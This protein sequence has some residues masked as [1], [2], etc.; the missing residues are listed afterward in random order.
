M[1]HIEIADELETTIDLDLV[2]DAARETLQYE[3]AP[4][5]AD[6]TIVLTGDE[7]VKELNRQYLD[8]DDTTDVL[9]FPA[10]FI[11]PDTTHTYLGDVIISYPK[12]KAQAESGGH[13]LENELKLL[14][15]HGLLHLLG[16]DHV[17]EE[18]KAEMWAVQTE[19]LSRL[20]SPIS[21]S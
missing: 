21:P 6:V 12:A 19:I 5:E 18:E 3:H 15:V 4:E 2:E 1:I 9:S 7:Q 8:I 11:D 10:D 17:D 13:S 14:V 20:D 16:Y